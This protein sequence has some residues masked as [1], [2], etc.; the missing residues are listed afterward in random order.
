MIRTERQP[1]ETACPEVADPALPGHVV[2]LVWERRPDDDDERE[3]AELPDVDPAE[4]D[5]LPSTVRVVCRLNPP[6]LADDGVHRLHVGAFGKDHAW[7]HLKPLNGAALPEPAPMEAAARGSRVEVSTDLPTE[8]VPLVRRASIKGRG[9]H[10]RPWIVTGVACHHPA[11][12]MWYKQPP[13]RRGPSPEVWKTLA[14][15]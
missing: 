6:V 12:V 1:W 7:R 11:Y 15:D 2:Q 8:V 5:P 10:F 9:L 14:E 13:E 4:L 3:M